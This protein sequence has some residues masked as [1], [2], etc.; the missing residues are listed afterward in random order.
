MAWIRGEKGWADIVGSFA[1]QYPLGQTWRAAHAFWLADDERLDE[2]RAVLDRYELD[3]SILMQEPFPF[4]AAYMMAH[5]AHDLADR[6]LAER[7]AAE[8]ADHVDCWSHFHICGNGPV[9][10]DLGICALTVG[11]AGRAVALLEDAIAKVTGHGYDG[12]LPRMRLELAEALL[13]RAATGDADRAAALLDEVRAF[14][15]RSDAPGLA[16][17]ADALAAHT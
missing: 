3:V 17:R 2:A 7:V 5:L 9:I 16:A 10:R 13:A 15:E 4:Q 12:L 6:H 14:A 11:E 8:L 1:D